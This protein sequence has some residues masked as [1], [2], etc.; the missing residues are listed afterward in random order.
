[1]TRMRTFLVRCACVAI[2]AHWVAQYFGHESDFLGGV[3]TVLL[4][5]AVLMP[6]PRR[7]DGVRVRLEHTK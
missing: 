6:V 1:M 7:R 2:A 4:M 3:G 5:A